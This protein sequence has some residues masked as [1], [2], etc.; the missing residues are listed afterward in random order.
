MAL[1]AR[2]SMTTRVYPLASL[3]PYKGRW[4]IKFWLILKGTKCHYKNVRAVLCI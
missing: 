1:A 3:N 2:M 4:T